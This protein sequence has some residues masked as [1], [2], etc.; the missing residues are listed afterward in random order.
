MS[1]YRKKPVEIEAIQWTGDNIQEILSF[2]TPE[3]P[4]YIGTDFSTSDEVFR[5]YTLE[6][7]ADVLARDVLAR[8]VRR[9]A[10]R[11][12]ARWMWL[13]FWNIKLSREEIQGDV[14]MPEVY[15]YILVYPRIKGLMK[16]KGFMKQV[17]PEYNFDISVRKN[18]RKMDFSQ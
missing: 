18:K 2:M 9:N 14:F 6:R 13:F 5:I 7:M 1:K 16:H 8:D 17:A 4:Q 11:Q 10:R 12:A 15:Y 3:K